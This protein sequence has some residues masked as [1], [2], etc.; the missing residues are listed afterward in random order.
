MKRR[1][2][3]KNASL[4]STPLI[5]NGFPLFATASTG[6]SLFDFLAQTTYGCGRILVIIQQNG[7]N[8]GL[9]TVI[10]VDKYTNLVNARS[11]ILLPQSSFLPLNGSVNTALHPAMSELQNLYNNG[12]L[13]IVQAVSY[14]NPNFSHFRATDIWFSGSSS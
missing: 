2:F 3:L 4:A 7:G 5:F 10:P 9:N 6:N 12:K 14:P 13:C 11:N 8:D 1:D